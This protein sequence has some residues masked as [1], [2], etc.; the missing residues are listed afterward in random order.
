MS[1]IHETEDPISIS[2]IEDLANILISNDTYYTRRDIAKAVSLLVPLCENSI[3][4]Y[5]ILLLTDAR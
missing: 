3:E 4:D 1:Q 5:R 2:M